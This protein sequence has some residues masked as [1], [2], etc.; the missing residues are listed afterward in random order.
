MSDNQTA[1]SEIMFTRIAN[2]L[3][4]IKSQYDVAV[5]LINAMKAAGEDV[6]EVEST[7]RALEI[8]QGKWTRM[9]ESRGYKV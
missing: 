2:D 1:G 6:T 5:D 7:L 9:L 3:S 8:R 4:A